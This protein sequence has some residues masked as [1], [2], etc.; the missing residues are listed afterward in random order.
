MDSAVA[1]LTWVLGLFKDLNVSIQM[2]ITTLS[3][4]K[5]AIQL[6]AN[7]IFHDR[8]KHTD[9]DSHFIREKL[10]AGLIQTVYVHSQQQE[11]DLL[12]KGLSHA[13]HL[14]LFSKLVMLNILLKCTSF[15][16]FSRYCT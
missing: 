10:K 8:V 3:D 15:Q 4:R 5:S 6:A 13:Q 7:P 12:T 16:Y 9:V 11:A 2:P 1:K 14:Y